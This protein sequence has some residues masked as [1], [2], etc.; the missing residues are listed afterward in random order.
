[1]F[2]ASRNL[3]ALAITGHAPTI[4]ARCSKRGNHCLG[5]IFSDFP[6]T[7]IRNSVCCG[8]RCVRF[9]HVVIPVT[10]GEV[11]SR[12]YSSRSQIGGLRSANTFL[13]QVFT[14]YVY[15]PE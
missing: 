1:M 7:L 4:F 10:V 6:L 15:Q 2:A 3:Y 11:I 12:K 9:N 14:W 5:T 13:I 8:D